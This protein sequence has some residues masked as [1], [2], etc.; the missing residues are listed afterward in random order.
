MR[1]L[2]LQEFVTLNGLASGE[3]GSVEYVGASTS[4]DQS[5]GR[6]QLE[7]FDAIDAIVLGRV[8]YQMFADYWPKVT[9]GDEKP[10]ADMINTT[11][12]IVFSRTLDHAPWGHFQEARIVRHNPIDELAT[13]KRQ[14]G[15]SMVIWGSI[16][17]A[18]TLTRAQ[19]I[20]EYR[21]VVCPIVLGVGRALFDDGALPLT[22]VN[23]QTH[24][25]GA[26]SL[27]YIN[28]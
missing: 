17:L 4:G 7:L 13:L 8:T 24:D 20:D 3:H 23:A 2:I 11:P 10:F 27:T 16:S 5:F 19:L 28:R 25:R 18:Q 14:S 9:A 21:M 6:A 26:V 15:K 22:L 12:K 1:K